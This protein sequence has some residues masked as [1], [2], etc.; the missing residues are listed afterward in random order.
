MYIPS[1][2]GF[3][4]NAMMYQF[5][6]LICHLQKNVEANFKS[7]ASQLLKI[8]SEKVLFLLPFFLQTE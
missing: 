4:Y 5:E 7:N 3:T 1:L 8:I 2:K 6:M